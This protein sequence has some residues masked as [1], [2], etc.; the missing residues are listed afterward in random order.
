[1]LVRTVRK[2]KM[3]GFHQSLRGRV[4]LTDVHSMDATFRKLRKEIEFKIHL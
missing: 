1:M 2:K 3:F 4:E